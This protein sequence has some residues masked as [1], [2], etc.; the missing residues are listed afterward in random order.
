M[1]FGRQASVFHLNTTKVP[2]WS[3]QVCGCQA[4]LNTRSVAVGH[5]SISFQ[6]P[7]F[8]RRSLK[9]CSLAA[10]DHDHFHKLRPSAQSSW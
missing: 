10:L 7:E 2:H 8:G 6:L 9:E 1:V 5:E 4:A 3:W